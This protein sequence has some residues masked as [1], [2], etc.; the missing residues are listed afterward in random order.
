[1]LFKKYDSIENSYRSKMINMIIQG[2][3]SDGVY[4]VTEK[5]HGANFSVWLDTENS[6]IKFAK[7]S[8]FIGDENFFN[9]HL[10]HEK[11]AED[12]KSLS[13]E[14]LNA[15]EIVITGELCGGHY[16][17]GDVENNSEYKAVQNG[18]WYSSKLQFLAFDLFI[19][20]EC[21]DDDTM[22]KAFD[23]C[24][25]P[26][27]KT[28]FKGSFD[29]C[30]NYSNE[31]Q[32]TIPEYFSLPQI[33]GN[34]C[35]GIVI[36]PITPSYLCSGQRVILKSKNSRHSEKSAKKPKK[37]IVL[38]GKAKGIV[39]ELFT[40]VTEN[41]LKNVVS[42]IGEVTKKDFGKIQGEMIKDIFEEY[43]K[44]NDIDDLEKSVKSIVN[45]MVGTQVSTL[46]RANFLNIVDGEF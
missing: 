26:H 30:L 22:K 4:V 36:K 42:K 14:H 28:L 16:P 5:V 2:G 38:E 43:L 45:K 33:D 12:I 6:V 9:S 18:L 31:F 15:K 7:R 10:I 27:L 32:T 41:R 44:D 34:I 19:D 39:E 3:H 20:G 23:K 17:H 25:L 1:M 35:E 37:V 24:E 13:S 40:L 8:G 46:I 21:V 11:L 29:E